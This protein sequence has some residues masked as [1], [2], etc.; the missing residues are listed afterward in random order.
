MIRILRFLIPLSLSTTLF[1]ASC[2]FQKSDQN[3]NKIEAN[4]NNKSSSENSKQE[5]R[6][7]DLDYTKYGI[8]KFDGVV[9][10][11]VLLFPAQTRENNLDSNGVFKIKLH[12]SPVK[13]VTGEW[14]AF[15]TEVQ[16]AKNN[17]LTNPL[18]IKKS[19]TLANPDKEYP[20]TWSFEKDKLENGK[21]YTFIFWK[22]DGSEKIVF[23]KEHINENLDIFPAKLP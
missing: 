14:I 23:S 12:L 6:N 1:I 4:K 9:K 20:L 2:Q 3:H 16:N 13:G 17:K 5:A 15:A 10:E 8:D 22:K 11:R 18:I 7:I 19:T 21:S